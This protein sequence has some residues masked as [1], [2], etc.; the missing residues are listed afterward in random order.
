[1]TAQAQQRAQVTAQRAHRITIVLVPDGEG[2][3]GD[4][5]AAGWPS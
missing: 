2:G 1:M 4:R 3:Y 5:A